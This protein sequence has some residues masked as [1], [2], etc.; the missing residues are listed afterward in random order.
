V[1]NFISSSKVLVHILH[2]GNV[3]NHVFEEL[4][5]TKAPNSDVYMD[6][7]SLKYIFTHSELNM[8]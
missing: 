2:L 6:H 3:V 5:K 4:R 7:K 8:R 1:Y